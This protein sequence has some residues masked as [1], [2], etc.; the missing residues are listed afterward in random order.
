MPRCV[1]LLVLL[2]VLA[3]CGEDPAP[4]AAAP[5]VSATL[6]VA[7]LNIWGVPLVAEAL[8]ARLARLVSALRTLAPDV[9]CLQEVFLRSTRARIVD[10]LGPGWSWTEGVQGGLLLGSRR[11]LLE[12]RFTPFPPDPDLDFTERLAGKGFLEAVV[13]TP[14]G[15]LR[16]VTTHLAAEWMVD[17][18]RRRQQD[19]L[20]ARL[21]E[22]TQN[23]ILLAGDL[24]TLMATAEGPTPAWEAFKALG[25]AHA[26]PPRRDADGRWLPGTRTRVGW[27]RSG[28]SGGWAPDHVLLR[29]G[30]TVDATFLSYTVGLDSPETAVSDHNLLLA[31]VRLVPR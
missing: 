21:A 14:A 1:L 24:N 12:S 11:A 10:G 4:S 17:G 19:R 20:L 30:P 6:E 16:V 15:P 28:R 27:P 31:T 3:A 29:S 7:C 23:P 22:R 5:A 26:E 25:F 18:P 13:A 9:I 2:V 8:D